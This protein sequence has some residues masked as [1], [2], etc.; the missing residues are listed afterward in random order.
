MN[1]NLLRRPIRR[2]A[3][4]IAA[5]LAIVIAGAIG[6]ALA[7]TVGS[8]GGRADVPSGLLY[9]ATLRTP[10]IVVLDTATGDIVERVPTPAGAHELVATNDGAIVASLYRA[11]SLLRIEAN[12]E[13]RLV[14]TAPRPHGLA[15]LENGDLLVTLGDAGAL[16]AVDRDGRERWRTLVGETPHAVTIG[17]GGFAYTANGGDGSVSVV[18]IRARS[19]LERLPAGALA[20]SID[21]DPDGTVFVANALDGTV[22]VLTAGGEIR[23]IRVGGKPVRVAALPGGNALVSVAA[24]GIVAMVNDREV[25]WTLPVGRAP[26]GIAISEDGR[27][28]FV[29]DNGGGSIVAIELATRT[30]AA[31]YEVGGG[32]SGLLFLAR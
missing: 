8:A 27:W 12:G 10:E 11:D 29:A 14:P 20:E 30:V 32:P 17:P 4:I 1:G 3:L 21:A 31:T 22:S 19:E 5:F 18:D 13:R 7:A 23:A 24:S 28:A 25:V 26:D 9:I 6:G 15:E 2:D 16:A